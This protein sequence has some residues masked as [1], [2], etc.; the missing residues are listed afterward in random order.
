MR[1]CQK[2]VPRLSVVPVHQTVEEIG[3]CL[4]NNAECLIR[5]VH[6]VAEVLQIAGQEMDCVADHRGLEGGA[7][8]EILSVVPR[9]FSFRL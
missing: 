8:L 3:H 7:V 9:T 5:A 6:Q 2:A 4:D 1:G